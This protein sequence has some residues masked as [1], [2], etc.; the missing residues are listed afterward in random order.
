MKQISLYTG[1]A[2]LIVLMFASCKDDIDFNYHSVHA[3][4][5]VDGELCNKGINVDISK[6]LQMTDTTDRDAVNNATVL[7][8]GD[9]GTEEALV[10]DSAGTYH[11]PSD[12][13]AK[14]GITYTLKVTIGE[15]SYT[16]YSTMQDTVSIDSASF[17]WDK[18]M[19]EDMLYYKV[20][21]KDIANQDNYY[22]Y[23]M[24]RNGKIYKWGVFS[25]LGYKNG[26]IKYSIV[27]MSKKKADKNDPSDYDNILYEGDNIHLDILSIDNRTYNYLY[28]LKLSTKDNS[29]PISN[30]DGGCLGYFAAYGK[31]SHDDVFSYNDVGE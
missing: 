17:K 26:E 22:C 28:S 2:T 7:L 12:I 8:S 11:S 20:D 10:C 14:K 19:N 27:C 21:I 18:I 30:F 31:V 25:D 9:D 3:I 6:T 16:S 23:R 29:N 1:I 24:Y 15:N 13:K 5:V 4:Y